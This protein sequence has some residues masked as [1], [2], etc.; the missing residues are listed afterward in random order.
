M[1]DLLNGHRM[2][3]F[4]PHRRSRARWMKWLRTEHEVYADPK[5][6]AS[7]EVD[8]DLHMRDEG[9]GDQSWWEN[10]VFQYVRRASTLG[11]DNPLGRQ[12]LCKGLACYT[13]MVESMIRVYGDPPPAGVPSGELVEESALVRPVEDTQ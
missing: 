10:Q 1:S 9:I 2:V 5:F 12:A 7:R 4:K 13:G 3:T 6:D 11:L 8:H